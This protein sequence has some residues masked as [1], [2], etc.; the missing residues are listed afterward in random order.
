[1]LRDATQDFKLANKSQIERLIGQIGLIP[2]LQI[3]HEAVDVKRLEQNKISNA[4]LRPLVYCT[5][6][7]LEKCDSFLNTNRI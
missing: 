2:E 5:G 3:V 7:R 1:M 4:I 6:H